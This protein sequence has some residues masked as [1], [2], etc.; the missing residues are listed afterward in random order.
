MVTFHKIVKKAL[1]IVKKA[2]GNDSGIHHEIKETTLR[3]F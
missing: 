2:S 3:F 1:E